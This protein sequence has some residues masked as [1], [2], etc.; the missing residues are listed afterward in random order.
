MNI[1]LPLGNSFTIQEPGSKVLLIGGGVGVA[2]LFLLGKSLSKRGVD[3]SFLLGYRTA[4]QVIEPDRFSSVGE[5]LIT[6]EDGTVG[7]KGLV[8]SHPVI[9]T[10]GYTHIFCCGPDPMMRGVAAIAKKN[11]IECEVSLENMMACG[12]GI[13]L[14]CVENTTGGNVNT[15]TEGPVFNINKLK[16]QI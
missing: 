9:T 1:I 5:L 11:K 2:P 12:I 4:N 16:W 6:T 10:G 15:C 7:H 8:T 3:F 13:C 14:C